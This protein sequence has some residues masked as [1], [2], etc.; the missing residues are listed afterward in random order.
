MVTDIYEDSR[1]RAVEMGAEVVGPDEI[2]DVEC[3]VFSPCAL[4]GVLNDDTAPRLRCE[5]VAGGANNQLL[6][7]EHGAE[8]HRRGI[9]YAPD[10]VINAGGIINVA[11][12]IGGVYRAERAREMTERIYETTARVIEA[13][14]GR[15]SA[16]PRCG[17]APGRAPHRV[18]AAP[19]ARVPEAA[20][21]NRG[22]VA[23]YC[24]GVIHGKLLR[25][26]PK[27]SGAAPSRSPPLV[28]AEQPHN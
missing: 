3:D 15:G 5:V 17:H 13:S 21:L 20:G 11:A 1:R 24:T 12:E 23:A 6:A 4:G 16:D 19:Q 14:A 8:L 22:A 25:Q 7:D 9:L 27:W 28:T 18:G 2:Y 26:P 10:F